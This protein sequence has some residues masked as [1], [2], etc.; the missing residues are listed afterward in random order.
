M[1]K[2]IEEATLSRRGTVLRLANVYGKGMSSLNVVST[3][4]SQIAGSGPIRLQSLHPV[5]D[6][7]YIDDIVSLVVNVCR[8]NANGIFNV[9]TG[10]GHSI[11]HLVDLLQKICGTDHDVISASEL[12]DHQNL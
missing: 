11:G 7:V 10:V 8:H 1:K 6:F 3:V 5:R 9:G 12:K 4:L 2:K